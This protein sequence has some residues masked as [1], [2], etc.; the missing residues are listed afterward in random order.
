MIWHC[1][2]HQNNNGRTKDSE[3]QCDS[4]EH[5]RCQIL[6]SEPQAEGNQEGEAKHWD[7]EKY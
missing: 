3:R 6:L 4:P 7:K 5:K 1:E 2:K